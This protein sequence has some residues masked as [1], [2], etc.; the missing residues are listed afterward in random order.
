MEQSNTPHLKRRQHKCEEIRFQVRYQE[1]E[2]HAGKQ[3][4]ETRVLG[5]V[6]QEEAVNNTEDAGNLLLNSAGLG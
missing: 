4:H 5:P 6:V 2:A 3:E 1:K